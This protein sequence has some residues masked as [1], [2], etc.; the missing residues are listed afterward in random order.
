MIID[1][2]IEKYIPRKKEK[3]SN[4]TFLNVVHNAF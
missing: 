4:Y 1:K 2:V 3:L